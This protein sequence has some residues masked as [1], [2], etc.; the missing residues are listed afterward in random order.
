MNGPIQLAWTPDAELASVQIPKLVYPPT[1]LISNAAA[2]S[3][4]V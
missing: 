3:A 2:I 1:T 4:R